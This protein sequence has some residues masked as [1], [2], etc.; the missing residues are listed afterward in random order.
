MGLFGWIRKKKIKEG[1]IS[2]PNNWEEIKKDIKDGKVKRVVVSGV[3]FIR[4]DL[5][6]ELKDE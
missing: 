3:E 4:A 2:V 5:I 1:I 6:K